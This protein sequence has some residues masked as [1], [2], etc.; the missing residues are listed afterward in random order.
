MQK[1][2]SR[3]ALKKAREVYKKAL[4]AEKRKIL[5][6]AG[7]GCIASGSLL[8][9]DK[10]AEIIKSKNV[11]CSLE[12][13]E[14]PGHPVGL[15][16]GGCPGFCNQSV[17]VLVEPEGWLYTKVKPEDAEEIVEQTIKNGKPVERLAFK[18]QDGKPILKK[19]EIPFYKKQTRIV[20]EQCGEIDAES[21]KEYLAVGGYS[22]FEKVLFDMT[23]EAVCK[24][25]SDS[26]LRG[27]GGAGFPAG[28]KWGDTLKAQGAPKYVVCNGDEG[29]PGAFMDQSVMEGIPHQMIEGMLIAAKA[30]GANQGYI[31]VRAEYPR[32]VSR[33]RMAIAQ[34]EE[35]GIL[36][37]KILGTDFS[38]KLTIYRGAGA[39]VCG[40]GSALMGSI[41]G[42]RGM[43][44]VKRYRST[45]R[46]LYEKPTVL[47]N[48]ETYANVPVIIN[49]GAAWYKKIGPETSPGTK[50]FALTGK[51][52]N[53]GLIEVPMGTK[54]REIIY[55]IGGGILNGK[56]FK[57]VQI[58][59]PSGGCLTESDLDMPLDFDSVPKAGAIIGSGGLVVMDETNCMIEIARFFMK[60]TQKESCGKCVPCREGTL[61]ML[62]TLERIVSGAGKEGD[63]ELLD[64]L[65][66][67]VSKAAL[68]GLGK[69]APNPIM[70]TLKR[71]RNEYEDHIYKKTCTA[72]ECQKLKKISIVPENCAGCGACSKV[73]PVGAITQQDKVLEG[74]KK[75]YYVLDASKCIKC[76]SCVE[77]CKFDAVKME[78]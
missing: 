32:A 48:V 25:V 21:I 15:K 50:T 16:K 75:A 47:N 66:V 33:L 40:E 37:D 74:K 63:I 3:D 36:G 17:L 51:I 65:S 71:F 44:R 76:M 42:R 11:Q 54:L 19:A 24:E 77:K 27:R 12:L 26:N 52:T 23:P 73:C 38:F 7:N 61:R 72:K 1:L 53:T 64:E 69:T 62:E 39:F 13:K 29:D 10:L 46:G 70:S 4:D 9:Y 45:E 56:K 5:V 35:A 59:G 68:C 20:L 41:E 14:E 34:A 60:F 2:T 30:I 8:V 18:G 58:G 43:P 49:K 67:T 28:Q 78:D 57:A 55:D 6:C 31:Y 22:A